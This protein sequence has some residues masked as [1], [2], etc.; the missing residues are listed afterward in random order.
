[1]P[2]VGHFIKPK[3]FFYNYLCIISHMRYLY[4]IILFVAALAYPA[5]HLFAMETPP[6][7]IAQ[8]E[9]PNIA[10]EVAPVYVALKKLRS[11]YEE[12][13]KEGGWPH[14]NATRG[15]I[16]PGARDARIKTVREILSV[17][18]DYRNDDVVEPDHYDGVLEQA[19]MQFQLRHGLEQDG[20]IGRG[21]QKA[22]SVPVQT[23]IAQI[24]ATLKRMESFLPT[25]DRFIVVNLPEYMLRAYEHGQQVLDMR[26]IVGDKKNPTPRFD[27]EISYVSF[28]P[29]WGVPTRIATEELLPKIIEDPN[30]IA[31]HGYKVYYMRG[32]GSPEV[33]PDDVPWEHLNTDVKKFP[34]FLRQQN[35]A[36]SALG[37]IKFG[38]TN[39]DHI[40]LHDTPTRHLF[41]RDYRALSH[42]C[43]RVEKPRELAHLIFKTAEDYD[44]ETLNQRYDGDKARIMK[45]EPL[46]VH[47]VYWTARADANGTAYFSE[48]IY[49]LD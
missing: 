47:L 16:E 42:G 30:Y 5:T 43:V 11:H 41:K 22:L 33:N 25:S 2:I 23:R 6:S 48:D 1:M 24:D 28:N 10:K 40:Y 45:V 26:V 39:S 14:F 49:T 4:H 35:S 27:N 15:K 38:M 46:P 44:P 19:V 36:S 34:Y 32:E 9:A 37:K 8:A 12:I 31:D 18:G 20:V 17:M 29:P 13:A 3:W 21:T 7:E